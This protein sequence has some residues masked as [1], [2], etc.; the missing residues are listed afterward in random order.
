MRLK[1]KNKCI[2]PLLVL[3]ICSVSISVSIF[4]CHAQVVPV[5]E[6]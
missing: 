3:E 5:P 2:N 6:A 4:S 1:L